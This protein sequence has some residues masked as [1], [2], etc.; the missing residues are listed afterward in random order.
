MP[1]VTRKRTGILLRELFAILLKA[2]EPMRARDALSQLSANVEM[3]EYEKGNYSSG[4]SIF[5]QIVRYATIDCVKAGWMIKQKGFWTVTDLGKQALVKYPDGETFYKEAVKLYN[6]WKNQQPNG[7]VELPDLESTE[8]ETKVA[9]ITF[10]QA[11]EQAWKEISE[12]LAR[13]Q[14]YEFQDL[15]AALIKAMGYHVAWVAPPGKDGGID[16]LAWPD[17]LGTKP[18]R[19]K[20]QVKRQQQT[21][22]VDGLRSFMA[23]LRDEDVGLFVSLGGFTKDAKD[24][25][26]MQENRKIRLLDEEQLVDLWVEHYDKI[27]DQDRRHLLL[28]PIYFLSPES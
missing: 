19:I 28:K 4:A 10:E 13:M 26:R 27:A 17:A 22:A 1:N 5:E 21:I 18:P 3:T 8:N 7:E 2:N 9:S 12:H 6:Q 11:E 16:I 24:E 23:M 20:V 14:P 25:A 15:V